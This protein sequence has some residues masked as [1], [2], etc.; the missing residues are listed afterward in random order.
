MN[1]LELKTTLFSEGWTSPD[2]SLAKI[3]TEPSN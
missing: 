1:T 3:Q 2:I